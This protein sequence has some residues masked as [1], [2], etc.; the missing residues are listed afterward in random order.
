MCVTIGRM[1]FNGAEVG[2]GVEAYSF[3]LADVVER[4]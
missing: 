3:M 4:R 1:H 2:A